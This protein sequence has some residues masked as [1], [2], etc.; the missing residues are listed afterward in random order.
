MEIEENYNMLQEAHP[1]VAEKY[2]NLI[3][4]VADIIANS[5][6]NLAPSEQEVIEKLKA[7]GR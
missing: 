4:M 3:N 2:L 5:D 6:E 1:D 7:I